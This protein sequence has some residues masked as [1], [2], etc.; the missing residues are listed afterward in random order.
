MIFLVNVRNCSNELLLV[1]IAADG[2]TFGWR[3]N[4]L[5]IYK[6]MTEVGLL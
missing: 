4:Y 1:A 2:S 5:K 6:F 3:H